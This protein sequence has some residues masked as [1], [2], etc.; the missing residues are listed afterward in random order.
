MKWLAFPDAKNK[1]AAAVSANRDVWHQK[2]QFTR[3]EDFFQLHSSALGLHDACTM[4]LTRKWNNPLQQE[5]FTQRVHGIRVWGGDFH[6]TTGAHGVIHAH[7]LPLTPVSARALSRYDLAALQAMDEEAMFETLE[8]HLEERYPAY[9]TNEAPH[10]TAPVELVWHLSG[11]SE[12]KQGTVSLAYYVNGMIDH[13]FLSFDA[14]ID[15]KTGAV[16]DF[17]HKSGEIATSPFASPINDAELF[18]YDQYLKDYN[19]DVIYDDDVNPDPGER[20]GRR[21]RIG[22][23]YTDDTTS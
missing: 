14:F 10:T 4:E 11:M 5:R 17:I 7:G 12:S 20:K 2:E 19:D 8:K 9:H 3:A 23:W 18:A 21:K 13:P 6:V 15:A 16:I 1:H 22:C